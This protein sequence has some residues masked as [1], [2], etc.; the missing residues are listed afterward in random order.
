MALEGAMDLSSGRISGHAY[1]NDDDD[2]EH[3]TTQY[4]HLPNG[5][6]NRKL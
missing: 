6:R 2:D 1:D 3:R 4:I 5:I